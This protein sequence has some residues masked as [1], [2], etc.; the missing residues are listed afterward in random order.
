MDFSKSNWLG[1]ATLIF[2]V[3]KWLIETFGDFILS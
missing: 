3:V 1:W 2:D